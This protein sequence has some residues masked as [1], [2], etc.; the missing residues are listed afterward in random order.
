MSSTAIASQHPCTRIVCYVVE[1]CYDVRGVS[2]SVLWPVVGPVPRA[3]RMRHAV[4]AKI[5]L[6]LSLST[7]AL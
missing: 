2:G 6:L 1:P 3:T 5:A 7:G 4:F